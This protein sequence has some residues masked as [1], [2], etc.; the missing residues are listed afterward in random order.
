MGGVIVQRKTPT[1]P[2]QRKLWEEYRETHPEAHSEFQAGN[3]TVAL[4][5]SIRLQG[6]FQEKEETG[7]LQFVGAEG[8]GKKALTLRPI[9][10]EA[11]PLTE[12]VNTA[13]LS[14][15]EKE[16]YEQ[17]VA[18]G[19][20]KVT[21]TIELAGPATAVTLSE[22]NLINGEGTALGLP[23]KVKLGNPFFGKGCYVGSDE[24]PIDIELTS[25]ISG[26]LTGKVGYL[27]SNSEG[28]LAT[29]ASDTL[30]NNTYA[31]PGVEGCGKNGD[32]DAA[33]DA[34]L[35]LP[36]EAGTNTAIIDGTLKQANVGVVEEAG[37]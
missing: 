31:A 11:R 17:D 33:I 32:A 35:A 37:Y 27:S 9:A 21:A 36:A 12:D 20:T 26:G 30:V 2:N 22:E 19:K 4:T 28:T 1:P 16:R 23:V 15:S 29:I 7:G 14:P 24:H 18:A 34:G 5:K 13:L 8:E 25:G 3:V 10:Q 6:G